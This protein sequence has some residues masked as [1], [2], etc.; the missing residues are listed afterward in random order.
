MVDISRKKMVFLHP[1]F[2][3]LIFRSVEK[4]KQELTAW[5]FIPRPTFLLLIIRLI[6]SM[7][8]HKKH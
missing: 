1:A 7:I 2:A 3:F 4:I 8:G 5:G 6:T